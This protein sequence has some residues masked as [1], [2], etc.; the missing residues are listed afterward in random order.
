MALTYEFSLSVSDNKGKSSSFAL[1]LPTTFSLADYGQ[2]AVSMAQLTNAIIVGI[3]TGANIRLDVDISGLTA[4]AATV[5]ADIQER[6]AFQYATANNRT[7]E[8]VIPAFNETLI[9]NGVD[10][11]DIVQVDAAAFDDMMLNGILAGGATIIPCDIDEEDLTVR[12]YA[13]ESFT[14]YSGS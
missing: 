13:R 4:N 3:I 11:V 10:D 6:A 8:V 5:N 12:N 9:S 2:Y 14:P 1:N 7:V